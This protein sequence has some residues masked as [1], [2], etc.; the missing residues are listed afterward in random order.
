VILG[1]SEISRRIFLLAGEP[2]GDMLGGRLMRAL[3]EQAPDLSFAGVGGPRMVDEG[4][5]SLFP[6][7]E[8]SLMGFA[9]ILPH[10]PRLLA[11]MRETVAAI[12]RFEPDMVLTI[13]SPGFALRLQHRLAGRRLLRLHYVAPQVWAWRRGRAKHLVRDLDHLLALLPFEP[14]FFE[15][16]GL[17]C[18]FVGHP[19]IE[20]AGQRGD[21]ARF[22]RR[23]GLVEDEPLLCLLPG[24]RRGEVANHL[25]VLEGAVTLLRQS[26]PGLRVVIPTLPAMAPGLRERVEGWPVP[27]LV[28]EDRAERFDAYAASRLAI[29]ASG[30]VSLEVALASVPF[31]TIYRTGPLTAWL[32]RRLI[33]VPHVNL[34]NLILDRAAVPE[35]LQKDCRADRIAEVAGSLIASEQLRSTQRA[36]LEEA[37][38]Q[39]GAA[40]ELPPSQRAAKQV[41]TVLRSL[42][43]RST[44]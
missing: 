28:L 22:R 16:Y 33:S 12:D 42:V 34:V 32:A 9:E 30:T 39:L 44:P 18:S 38:A 41:L 21:G 43:P 27:T 19:I 14:P 13:D 3:H 25:P 40:A 17:P 11:R 5:T 1:R 7:D 23:H 24:S 36:A 2:S 6:M 37:A 26:F 20:E 4:L 8:L 31:V 10:L 29:A 35:L 15:R